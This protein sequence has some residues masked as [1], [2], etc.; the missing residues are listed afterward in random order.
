M[1]R[2]LLEGLLVAAACAALAFL[3]NLASPRGLAITQD[4]FHLRAATPSSPTNPNQVAQASA[5]VSPGET[6]PTEIPIE[7]AR[8]I[9]AEGLQPADT[10]TVTNLFHDS[11]REQGLIVFVDAR[12]KAHYEEGH[13]PGAYELDYYYAQ[14]FVPTVL[15]PCQASE[16]IVVYC[17]GG[18]CEDSRLAAG[19]LKQL[20]I[21][22]SK[23]LVYAAGWNQWVA[24]NMPVEIGE[25]NS[26]RLKANE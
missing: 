25:R 7:T 20:G 18:S 19:L 15:P 6:G 26:G 9:R 8:K 12:D 16:T 23:L 1:K 24:M 5:P 17:T 13:I 4:Y 14:D 11:R 10:A 3:A 2:V 21:P 22:S